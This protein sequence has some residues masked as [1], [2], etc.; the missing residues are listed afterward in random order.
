MHY[1]NRLSLIFNIFIGGAIILLSLSGAAADLQTNRG[2]SSHTNKTEKEL[3]PQIKIGQNNQQP[4]TIKSSKLRTQ[5][6]A[7]QQPLSVVNIYNYLYSQP[8]GQINNSKSSPFGNINFKELAFKGNLYYLKPQTERLPDFA[9]I[10]PAGTIYIDK[11][12]IAKRRFTTGFPGV[13]NRFE[14][15]GI[16][17]IAGFKIKSEGKYKFRLLSDDGAKL[18]IDNKLVID[19]DGIHP[20]ATKSGTI[21]LSPGKHLIQVDYFQGP[22]AFIALQLYITEPAGR[23]QI[24]APEF[25]SNQTIREVILH[26]KNENENQPPKFILKFINPSSSTGKRVD[27]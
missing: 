3:T 24:F 10:T 17:Y 13:N 16:R 7:E 8:K 6:S 15:F 2:K 4:P 25:L 23:E 18:W 5:N 1:N 27:E 19:N 20:P 26:N 21:N 12:N 22:R 14:W 9:S 11:L